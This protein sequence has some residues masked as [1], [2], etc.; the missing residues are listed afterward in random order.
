MQ[1]PANPTAQRLLL[2]LVTLTVCALSMIVAGPR[3]SYDMLF[4]VFLGLMWFAAL[5]WLLGFNWVPI[6]GPG[7][8]RIISIITCMAGVACAMLSGFA[9]PALALTWRGEREAVTV[10]SKSGEATHARSSA[11]TEYTYQLR[12]S[13]GQIVS[14]ELRDSSGEFHVGDRLWATTDPWGL[15]EPVLDDEMSDLPVELTALAISIVAALAGG[16]V[17][18]RFVSAD[19]PVEI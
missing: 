8:F 13:T 2:V 19:R 18:L 10:I 11:I 17:L 5:V 15:I 7:R 1:R 16:F 9:A 14:P 3:G 12:T 6:L 4:S